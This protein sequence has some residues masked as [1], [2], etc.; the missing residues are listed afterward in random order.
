MMRLIVSVASSVCSVDMHQVAGLGRR[1][2]RL[3][4][5][6]V[7]HLADEDH[8]GILAQGGAQ[9]GGEAVGVDA[10]L[11]LVHDRARSRIRNSIGSSIVMMWQV[12]FVLM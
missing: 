4:R 1:Q 9:R 10:D 7:A 2:R 8:V 5:L 6:E 3:D 12:R 11:A